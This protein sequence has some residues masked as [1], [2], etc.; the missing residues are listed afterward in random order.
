MPA[1]E[2]RTKARATLGQMARSD[3]GAGRGGRGARPLVA[4]AAAE[5]LDL[6]ALALGRRHLTRV[7]V[8]LP[9]G[10]GRGGGSTE[11][12]HALRNPVC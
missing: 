12:W 1:G 7:L 3:K 4:A 6:V 11:R 9:R 8:H 2:T 10:E 5:L